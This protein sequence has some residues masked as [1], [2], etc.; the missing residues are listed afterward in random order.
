MMDGFKLHR[1]YLDRA[2][3]AAMVKD[4]RECLTSAPLFQ[5]VMPRTGKSF[6][7]RMSN[8]GPFGWVSDKAGGYR[9]QARHPVTDTPW[10]PIPDS[11]L[12]VWRAL[13]DYD[14]EPEACLINWYAPDAKMGLHR[15]TDEDDRDAPVLS[16][17]LGDSAV[18]RI[19]PPEKGAKTASVKLESGDVCL[20]TG[21]ARESR[22]GIDRVL[23][24]SSTLLN[25]PGRINV[26]LRRVSVP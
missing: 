1:A 14:A 2:A 13:A 8:A 4:I 16:I 5:P 3:Q 6:S 17:S 18:F 20:L 23:G 24:G 21:P 15:D 22:H 26:T 11:I 7:V 9:Y 25:A 12:S 19:G 10:P